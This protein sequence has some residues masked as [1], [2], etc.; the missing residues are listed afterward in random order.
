MDMLVIGLTG[1][2]G[3]GKSE[4][5]RLLTSYGAYLINADE[6]GH[7][8]YTPNSEI[9]SEVVATFGDGRLQ[10][11][12][13][14]DRKKLGGIVFSDPDKL[15]QLNQI[16]HPRLARMVEKRINKLRAEGVSV[17]VVEAALLFEAGWDSLVDEVWVTDSPTD[18]VVQ[19]IQARNGLSEEEVRKRINSQMSREERNSRADL[20]LDNSGNVQLLEE[21]VAGLWDARVEGRTE[22]R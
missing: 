19:R 5:A 17:V 9:W 6:V 11:N 3:T 4:V 20:V 16:M 15:T 1:S 12:R 13:E 8:A 10:P 21:T 18:M 14:I 2:I 22:Q 7:D